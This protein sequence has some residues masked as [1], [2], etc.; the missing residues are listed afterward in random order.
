MAKLPSLPSY[1]SRA[2]WRVRPTPDDR[3]PTEWALRRFNDDN[4]NQLG[5]YHGRPAQ[6]LRRRHNRRN[7]LI[8]Q[9]WI[10]VPAASA[11]RGDRR[12][13]PAVH[14]FARASHL[15]LTA[16]LANYLPPAA[17]SGIPH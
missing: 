9:N 2:T 4:A 13:V 1:R 7:N 11:A 8:G 3:P 15:Q 14:A 5:V 16:N 12:T 17:V 6:V 10:S